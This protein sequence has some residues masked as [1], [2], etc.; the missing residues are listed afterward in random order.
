MLEKETVEVLGGF[1]EQEIT[2][3]VKCVCVCSYVRDLL[4]KPMKEKI[5]FNKC[6]IIY[7]G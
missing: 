7:Y 3:N 2:A 6:L 4:E 5:S 1:E